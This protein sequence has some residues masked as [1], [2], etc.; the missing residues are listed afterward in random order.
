L[1]IDAPNVTWFTDIE[2]VKEE[3][4]KSGVN[5][6]EYEFPIRKDCQLKVSYEAVVVNV[7]STGNS[8]RIL[9]VTEHRTSMA[10][11]QEK[12]K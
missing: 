10:A 8:K 3:V 6:V 4:K 11:I 12:V 7:D 9:L 1:Q 5:L 2:K